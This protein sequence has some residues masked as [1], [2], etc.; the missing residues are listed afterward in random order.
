MKT[1][2]ERKT[3][4]IDEDFQGRVS[5]KNEEVIDKEVCLLE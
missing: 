1:K 4:Y 2:L 3:N 5:S